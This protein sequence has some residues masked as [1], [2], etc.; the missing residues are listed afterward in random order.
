MALYAFDGTWNKEYTAEG[1]LARNTNVKRFFELYEGVRNFHVAGVGT[2]LGIAGRILGGAFGLSGTAGVREMYGCLRRNYEADDRRIDVVGFSRGAAMALDFVNLIAK[3]GVVDDRKTPRIT[4]L[5]LF[6]AVGSFGL[7]LNAGGP[8][9]FQDWD[10]GY[11]QTLPDNVD[12]CCHALALDERRQ[13]FAVH[14]VRHPN[15]HEVWFAGVHTD[16]GGGNGNLGLNDISLRWMGMMAARANVP[17]FVAQR[18][19]AA[20][21][22]WNSAARVSPPPP[23]DLVQNKW[24]RVLPKDRVH[25]SVTLPR[26]DYNNPDRETVLTENEEEAVVGG[27]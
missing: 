9:K 23:Y 5:A 16:V 7:N 6:D 14:R 15:A 10:V 22:R 1:D 18:V 8:A 4:F 25:F 13:T 26:P 3:E 27:V 21:S 17:G 20:T 24:R 19:K 2:K 11:A 12:L